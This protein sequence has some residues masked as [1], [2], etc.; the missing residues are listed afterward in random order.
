MAWVKDVY[1]PDYSDKIG[2]YRR[3]AASAPPQ[4]ARVEFPDDHDDIEAQY[5]VELQ[6][7]PAEDDGVRLDKR[8]RRRVRCCGV[9]DDE[10]GTCR[11]SGKHGRGHRHAHD[12]RD[13]FWNT[14]TLRSTLQNRALLGHDGSP[15]WQLARV[16]AS[17]DLTEADKQA[18]IDSMKR[19]DVMEKVFKYG[20]I[21]AVGIMAIVAIKIA[22][23]AYKDAA[24][25]HRGAGAGSAT[26]QQS[27]TIAPPATTV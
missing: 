16:M 26:A 14:N 1:G 7:A 10:S 11:C 17:Q 27:L 3:P 9:G 8:Y 5:N 23:D 4:S 22:A 12:L 15:E 24:A 25:H 21:I 18:F 20:T 2:F 6:D 13:D 19:N